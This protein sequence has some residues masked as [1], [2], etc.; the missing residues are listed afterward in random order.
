MPP[1][2]DESEAGSEVV[3]F[4]D[5]P[6]L[7]PDEGEH[8]TEFLNV[9]KVSKESEWVPVINSQEVEAYEVESKWEREDYGM[10]RFL[11]TKRG[12]PDW[13]YV[14]KRQTY[15]LKD[16][17]LVKEEKVNEMPEDYD[18]HAALPEGVSNI[19]TV[20]HYRIL[21]DPVVDKAKDILESIQAEDVEE[22]KKVTAVWPMIVAISKR[23]MA[24]DAVKEFI[25]RVD[26]AVYQVKRFHSDQ[27]KEFMAMPM[28]RYLRE[29]R[30]WQ[31]FTAGT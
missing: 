16:K 18:W 5:R 2:D 27:A 3:N 17:S 20:L 19:K 8:D 26:R 24:I 29:Q 4:E 13:C 14:Y 23:S 1:R 12:G 7:P 30:V 11:T 6:D 31:T 22:Q 10:K 28:K 15:N 21:R 25:S 9:F